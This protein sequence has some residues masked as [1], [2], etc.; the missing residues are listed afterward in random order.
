AEE[1][2]YKRHIAEG[3]PYATILDYAE[4]LGADLIVMPSHKRSRIDKVMLG[5][6]ASKVVENSPINVMVVKPQG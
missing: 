4:R 5:S 3:K 6:V 1:V 2:V